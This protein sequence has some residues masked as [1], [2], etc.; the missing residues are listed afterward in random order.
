MTLAGRDSGDLSMTFRD[1]KSFGARLSDLNRTL[2][3]DPETR[4]SDLKFTTSNDELPVVLRHAPNETE[5]HIEGRRRA[6]KGNEIGKARGERKER[7][8]KKR[9]KTEDEQTG[10][11]RS[12][13]A[14]SANSSG[15]GF[16]LS[17]TTP[18]IMNISF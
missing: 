12:P 9:R 13:N 17:E 11:N 7:E 15:L 3:G 1:L 10:R 5:G 2:A 18:I 8:R 14:H 16:Q 6:G 4:I